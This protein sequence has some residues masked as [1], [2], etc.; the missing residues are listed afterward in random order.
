[1]IVTVAGRQGIR[2]GGLGLA[3]DATMAV[4]AIADAVNSVGQTAQPADAI[5]AVVPAVG[6]GLGVINGLAEAVEAVVAID[7]GLVAGI[8]AGF[9]IAGGVIGKRGSAGIG[10]DLAGQI[11]EAVDLILGSE[12]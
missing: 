3:G 8:G 12:I 5:G 6:D 7:G 1:R 2:A 10:A 11:T 9:D 4:V